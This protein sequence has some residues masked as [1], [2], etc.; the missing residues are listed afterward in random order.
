MTV[1]VTGASGH[2][3]ANLVR[4]L[5]G[6]GRAVRALVHRNG[7]TLEGLSLERVTGDV[8]DPASLDRAFAGAETV[9]HLAAR[10]TIGG[11][12]PAAVRAVNVEGTRNVVEACRRGGARRLVHFASIHALSARPAGEVV[13]EA[14]SPAGPGAPLY[15][16]TKAEG[17][18]AVLEGVG[19][20]LD[21]VVLM[22]TAVIGPADL[23]PSRMGQVLLDLYHGR[24][25]ALVEGG[26]DWVDVRDVVNGALAAERLGAPGEGYILSGR[27]VSLEG[28]A[29]LVARVE[30][31]RPPR[32]V[33]P[34]WLARA[35]A[36]LALGWSRVSGS[37]PLFTPT[38]LR[39]LRNHRYV[40]HE[41]AARDLGWAPRP[42]EST[43]ADTFEWF[44][45]A[46]LLHS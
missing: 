18:G 1:A 45:R 35:G 3:G 24:F 25:P 11:E 12:P 27:W 38:A 42:L 34:M 15:D 8:R 36:P 39:A 41:K 30:G 28:L 4:A 46:G 14:R 23:A 7:R 29:A 10:I 22:P 44:R 9:F 26:F 21:A 31:A 17:V 2:I 32:L 13:D 6:A 20:G 43:I 5:L 16:R 40:S 19:R 33:C 37:R